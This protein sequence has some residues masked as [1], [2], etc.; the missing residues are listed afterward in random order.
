MS[1][2]RISEFP[3]LV[4][5]QALAEALIAYQGTTYRF[6]LGNIASL[7]P[8]PT[9][10]QI[11][12]GN[13]DNVSDAAK[14]VSTAQQAALDQKANVQHAH[15]VSD[16][17]GLS[18]TLSTFTAQLSNV[19]DSINAMG[20]QIFGIDNSLSSILSRLSA[21]EVKANTTESNVANLSNTI[22]TLNGSINTLNSHITT[23]TN[24]IQALTTVVAGLS[25]RLGTAESNVTALQNANASI[26][27]TL[28]NHTASINNLISEFNNHESRIVVLEQEIIGDVPTTAFV[29][30]QW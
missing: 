2:K 6:K 23:N 5:G 16:V 4:V 13:V 30:A 29:V 21:V 15:A 11:G 18:N 12:L 14:P 27:N 3:E 22:T 20:T 1:A 9:K 17:T 19:Y 8:V 26:Q 24:D 28:S 7:I 25:S 10:A